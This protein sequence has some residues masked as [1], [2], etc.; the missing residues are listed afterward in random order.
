[1]SE[2]HT[3]YTEKLPCLA[4]RAAAL[5]YILNDVIMALLHQGAA[6]G[7]VPSGLRG[8]AV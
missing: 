3:L 1:M 4:T 8:N 2:A 5:P 6:E 7:C